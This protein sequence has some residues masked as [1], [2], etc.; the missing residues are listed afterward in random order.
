MVLVLVYMRPNL[1]IFLILGFTAIAV[2]GFLGMNLNGDHAHFGCL[3]ASSGVLPCKESNPLDF[4]IFHMSAY[5][6]FSSAV[7][8]Y[9]LFAAPLLLFWVFVFLA[10]FISASQ[11]KT[12]LIF[13]RISE[14]SPDLVWL[15]LKKSILSW[16]AFRSD[17]L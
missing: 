13:A 11:I 4:S 5:K 15:P 6:N 14:K 9:F 1:A 2:F 17:L 3:G 12:R 8:S 7:L 10:V 16:Q